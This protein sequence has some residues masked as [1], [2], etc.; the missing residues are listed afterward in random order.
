MDS[1]DSPNI[2]LYVSNASFAAISS[3]RS[4][5]E[6]VVPSSSGGSYSLDQGDLYKRVILSNLIFGYGLTDG[7][8]GHAYRQRMH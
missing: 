6:G 4:F 8:M 3:L 5:G 7:I 2:S 1:R